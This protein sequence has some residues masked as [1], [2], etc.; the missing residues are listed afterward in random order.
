LANGVA[1]TPRPPGWH[2]R[3]LRSVR[4]H[5]SWRQK[6]DAQPERVAF[7]VSAYKLPDQLIRLVER[8]SPAAE[9]VLVHVDKKTPQPDYHRMVEGTSQLQNVVFL[10]RHVN[11]WG[12]FGVVQATLKGLALLEDQAIAYDHLLI[13]TGQC[14]PLRPLSELREFLRSHRGVSFIE[15][16]PMPADWWDWGGLDRLDNL[17]FWDRKGNHI[18]LPRRRD[19]RFEP[20]G[21]NNA[22]L[23]MRMRWR[24]WSVMRPLVPFARHV[25][26]LHP[27]GGSSYWCL[28]RQA[29]Y[30]VH[31]FLRTH[32]R[33]VRF[34]RR[35]FIPDE[36]FFQT[37]LGN[38]PLR[39]EIQP[40][41]LHYI[42]WS[43]GAHPKIFGVEDLGRL[44][45]SGQFFARKFDLAVDEEVLDELDRLLT[46]F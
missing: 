30:Y 7:I 43:G 8:L 44:R 46:G 22:S 35:T 39:P 25:D 9:I 16:M 26:G 11:W 10:P 29:V 42:E 18:V 5:L 28:S 38:S 15:Y 21:T 14:Y 32:P 1:E 6:A 27:F 2:L 45:E 33:Y 4:R 17:Y 20:L 37:I 31:C 13:L 19:S 12:S 3:T 23:R 24:L 41:N 34:M 40:H 36:H